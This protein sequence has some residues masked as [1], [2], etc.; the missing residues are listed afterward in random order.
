LTVRSSASTSG[1]AVGS[2]A[3]GAKVAV[4]CKATGTT[5][6]GTFGT[7][8]TWYK[9]SSGYISAAYASL[10]GT[11]SSCTTTTPPPTNVTAARQRIIDRAKYWYDASNGR[12]SGVAA[13][14]RNI[15]GTAKEGPT[16]TARYRT[17][18]SGM[19][20]M[21]WELGAGGQLN[22]AGFITTAQAK[23]V[24]VTDL[25]AGDILAADGH[26]T[27]FHTWAN[28]AAWQYYAYDFGGG[29][30]G[31]GPMEYKVYTLNSVSADK[32]KRNND[33][34]QYYA[35]RLVRLGD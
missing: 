16:G 32:A 23:K 20:S 11:V 27:M 3:D 26:V 21:A 25:K 2:L 35:R 9:I 14:G 6:T 7:T 8:A 34:R 33:S 28:K 12:I 13:F 1:S 31:A 18:C 4:T 15:Y 24:N 29:S 19:I 10:S 5:V 22:S 30:G 17:D